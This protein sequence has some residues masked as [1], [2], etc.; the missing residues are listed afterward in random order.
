MR[1]TS[2]CW[3]SPAATRAAS[4]PALEIDATLEAVA[5][6]GGDAGYVCVD[7]A[8]EALRERLQPAVDRRGGVVSGVVHGAGVLAD[9]RLEDKRASDFL[10]VFAPKVRGL[11]A[12]LDSLDADALRFVIVFSSAAAFY[13]NPGQADYA[14]ANEVLNKAAYRLRRRLPRCRV[15]A[16]DWAPWAGGDGMVTPA[17]QNAFEARGIGLIEP[18]AG[19]A[20]VADALARARRHP[21]SCSSGRASRRRRGR[22]TTRPGRTRSSGG[23]RP[24]RTRSSTIT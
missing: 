4:P 20:I 16:F 8:D 3:W 6:A 2:R 18:E 9:R 11:R 17:L 14:I 12:L 21:R 1:S 23:W 15:V 22:S 19:A 13:G 5:P 24:T 10:R 7:V